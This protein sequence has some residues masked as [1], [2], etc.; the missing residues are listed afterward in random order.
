LWPRLLLAAL[1]IQAVG[2]ALAAVA[3]GVAVALVSAF[4]FGVT[5]IGIASMALAIGAHLRFP[6]PWRPW[7]A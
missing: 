6:R 3:D 1:V 4:L 5:F 2:I 7:L